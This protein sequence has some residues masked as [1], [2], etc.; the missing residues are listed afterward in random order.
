MDAPDLRGS[1]A[2]STQRLLALAELIEQE[3]WQPELLEEIE[4]AGAT[5]M[6]G[7][8]SDYVNPPHVEEQLLSIVVSIPGRRTDTYIEKESR[9]SRAI[10]SALRCAVIRPPIRDGSELRLP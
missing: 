6:I 1:D 4:R 8:G 9:L 5:V 10:A 2:H 3:G 7:E